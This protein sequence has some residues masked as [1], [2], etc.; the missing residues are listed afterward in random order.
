M[1]EVII[2]RKQQQHP[3]E[4]EKAIFKRM[5][6]SVRHSIF[7]PSHHNTYFKPHCDFSRAQYSVSLTLMNQRWMLKAWWNFFSCCFSFHSNSMSRKS[8]KKNFSWLFKIPRKINSDV[9]G[10]SMGWNT[11]G[12]N[13]INFDGKILFSG[14]HTQK[15]CQKTRTRKLQALLL[16]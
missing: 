4:G 10:K 2:I 8:E 9:I 12:E 16:F 15:Y 11:F 14:G 3:E 5:E 7:Y 1:N 6:I 13:L